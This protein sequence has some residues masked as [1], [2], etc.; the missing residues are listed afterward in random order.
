MN[1]ANALGASLYLLLLLTLGLVASGC[2][3]DGQ[4]GDDDDVSDDDDDSYPDDDDD[5]QVDDD[6]DTGPVEPP[7]DDAFAEAL[8]D[9]LA[10]VFADH[11]PPGL[12]VAVKAPG[13]AVW[14]AA[15]GVSD[16]DAGTAMQPTDRFKA[17]E[18]TKGFVAATLLQME[19][20]DDLIMWQ[21]VPLWYPAAPDTWTMTTNQ[22]LANI[23]GA[24]D[25]R[26][27][28]SF[29]DSQA[30][31]PE[32][33]A[34]MAIE[35]PI[36]GSPG[37]EWQAS[38]TNYV[39]A[40]LIAEGI[41]GNSWEQ[42]TDSRFLTTLDLDDTY[43]PTGSNGWGNV[44]PGYTGTTDVSG[45]N[46]PSA[47]SGAGSMVST[48]PD[49][50]VWGA[51]LYGGD[52]L[53]DSLGA[54]VSD[55]HSLVPQY[56]YG[57]ATLIYLQNEGGPQ[58]WGHASDQPGYSAWMGYRQEFDT[59]VVLMG[60]DDSFDPMLASLDFWPIVEQHVDM[61]DPGDDDDAVY[62]AEPEGQHRLWVFR[63]QLPH[64]G[65]AADPSHDGVQ[66]SGW[67]DFDNEG[68]TVGHFTV[69]SADFSSGSPTGGVSCDVEANG[70]YDPGDMVSGITGVVYLQDWSF[71]GCPAWP[72]AG[73]WQGYLESQIP[74]LYLVPIDQLTT[75]WEA[76]WAGAS[77]DLG[78]T[79]VLID[80][81]DSWLTGTGAG[82][83]AVGTPMV[84]LADTSE[85]V[86][87]EGEVPPWGF[88][89]FTWQT[90]GDQ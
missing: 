4:M 71:G 9:H 65:S 11:A 35:L 61:V 39:V 41:S 2:P 28:A 10:E 78:G 30:W 32:A 69:M 83:G 60:N 42:E 51:A 67:W 3:G 6:D 62:L 85:I 29:D 38:A 14:S 21:V 37:A 8:E 54:M 33:L 24:P 36:T 82:M 46:H 7:I 40:G 27:H 44:I 56:R 64:A 16:L 77:D 19:D 52:V 17:G 34:S 45:H 81:I 76:S 75:G 31:E 25:Y 73:T 47:F 84:I 49:L 63:R 20:E 22:L 86:G 68:G 43:L 79:T 90:P 59:S 80:F 48:A 50:A 72:D 18:I 1:Q 58:L 13:H 15:L 66:L 70:T 74:A 26:D 12:V 89:G 5:D 88:L 23:G 53:G 87:T 55:A 57:L